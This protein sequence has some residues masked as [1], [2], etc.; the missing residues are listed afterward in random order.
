[1]LSGHVCGT[2]AF[3]A[4]NPWASAEDGIQTKD[5]RLSVYNIPMI[6]SVALRMNAMKR[7]LLNVLKVARTRMTKS[8]IVEF[9]EQAL[10][11]LKVFHSRF[12]QAV[13]SD[14]SLGTISFR[15]NITRRLLSASK[16]GM[17]SPLDDTTDQNF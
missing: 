8:T 6:S 5:R 4:S 10:T 3:L 7:D 15:S 1:M 9:S 12:G 11:V 17:N 13:V 2:F 14:G 16:I